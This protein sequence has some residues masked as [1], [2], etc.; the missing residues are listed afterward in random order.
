MLGLDAANLVARELEIPWPLEVAHTGEGSVWVLHALDPGPETERH[1]VALDAEGRLRCSFEHPD[2][3]GLVAWGETWVAAL[4]DRGGVQVFGSGGGRW[5]LGR[6]TEPVQL[7]ARGTVLWVASG[8]E[9]LGFERPWR[10][11][12]RRGRRAAA[13]GVV[14]TAALGSGLLVLASRSDGGLDLESYNSRLELVNWRDLPRGA[15][16][17]FLVALP[18]GGAWLV[19]EEGVVWRL[20]ARG[21]VVLRRRLLLPGVEEACA[22]V[23]GGLLALTPGALLA[24]DGAGEAEPGQGGLR[25]AADLATP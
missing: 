8:A 9:L 10:G 1:L 16:R 24:L 12:S 2:V 11:A 15:P 21:A 5:C 7:A 23:D 6:F 13:T 17:D 22:G 14:R 18:G 25:Y 19:G 4:D 20:D 3:E